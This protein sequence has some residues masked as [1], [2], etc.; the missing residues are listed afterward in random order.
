MEKSQIYG[1][2]PK[3]KE[4][5]PVYEMQF[6][7][8]MEIKMRQSKLANKRYHNTTGSLSYH[9]KIIGKVST[10]IIRATQMKWLGASV[11]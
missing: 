9:R 1:I 11:I 4:P 7:F 5:Q 8:S 2:K 10:I 3:K 6:P